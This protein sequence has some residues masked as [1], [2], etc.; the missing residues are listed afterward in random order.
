MRVESDDDSLDKDYDMLDS[1]V[2]DD[3]FEE[4]FGDTPASTP[5]SSTLPRCRQK[6]LKCP[7]ENCVKAFNRKV[8]LEEHIRS[9]TNERPFQCPHPPCMKAFFRDSHLKHHVKSQH[10]NVRDYKC[11]WEGCESSFTTGTRL[12]RHIET[13]EAKERFRCRG[14]P[15]CDQTF[16]KQETLDRHILSVHHNI[17][18][19]PCKELDSVTGAPCKK[20]YDTAENLRC[21]MRAKHDSTRFSCSDCMAQNAAILANP[22]DDRE[23][24]RASFATYGELQAH[25]TL[26]HPPTCQYCPTSFTTNKELT[27]HLEIQHGILPEKKSKNPVVFT[28]TVEGC[29]KEFTK[30]GNL[31]VHIKTVHENKRDFVCG[32]TEISLPEEVADQQDAVIHG[33]NR[34]FTSKASLEEHVR[35]AHL[36]LES[37]RMLREKK[38]K[39][40]RGSEDEQADDSDAG[41]VQLK[42]QRRPRS[43]K[44]VKRT[45]AMVGLTGVAAGPA[46]TKQNQ[47]DFVN[48]QRRMIDEDQDTSKKNTLLSG[49]MV[50]CDDHIWH[51][52]T[53]YHYPSGEYPTLLSRDFA[54]A[55][56]QDESP[57][58][59]FVHAEKVGV[60]AQGAC[61]ES[62]LDFFGQFEPETELG[63][64]RFEYPAL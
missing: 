2:D 15:G 18:P 12:R 44:G 52:G 46:Q 60:G 23:P 8:R 35:T 51:N 13:H 58:E 30:K 39:A 64:Q 34:S 59:D 31:N 37:K 32:K 1:D 61:D 27:R 63:P 6:T 62:D 48:D 25:L 54:R 26:V 42:K 56:V 38:R 50:I 5:P 47:H 10:S 14:Y 36:G 16:R 3:D 55:S 40:D 24:I 45:S 41:G 22:D 43:D 11:T 4:Q 57:F 19:F 53:P 28:C 49:S 33:C 17:K 29:G 20:A 7:Y 9:H 21:H